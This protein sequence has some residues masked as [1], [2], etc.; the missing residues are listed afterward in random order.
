MFLLPPS[1]GVGFRRL[2]DLRVEGAIT[3][4]EERRRERERERERKRERE[5]SSSEKPADQ[6]VVGFTVGV[7][8]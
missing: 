4:Q 1:W 2:W 3:I 7:A 5:T 8:M 6:M